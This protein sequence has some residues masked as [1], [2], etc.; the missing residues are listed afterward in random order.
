M[1]TMTD[2]N[3]TAEVLILALIIITSCLLVF[4]AGIYGTP[5]WSWQL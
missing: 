3:H 2:R 1:M 4:A 5:D